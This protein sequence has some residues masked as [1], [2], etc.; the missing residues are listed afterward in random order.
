MILITGSLG[1]V[2]SHISTFFEKKNIN[3]VGID[4]LSYSYKNNIFNK[5]KHYIFDISDK[6]K[7][8][9][10]FKKYNI[11]T[12]IH[13]AAFSYVLEAESNKN[14]YFNN[15]VKKTKNFINLCKKYGIK[16][17][18]FMSSS[19][20]YGEN[21]T[22]STFLENDPTSPKNFYGKNKLLIENYLKKIKFEKLIILRLFNV[23]GVFNKKFKPFKFKNK[24]YQRLIFKLFH[25]LKFKKKTNINFIQIKNKKIFPARDFIDILDLSKILLKILKNLS[26]QKKIYEIFNIGSGQSTSIDEI[27]KLINKKFTKKLLINYVN[28]SKKELVITKA[29]IKKIKKFV[30]YNKFVS[31][32]KSLKSYHTL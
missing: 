14:K 16:N 5:K 26:Q 7:L 30:N 18:I 17:F 11:N 29:S 28:L 19:N 23:I 24:N 8:I 13:C 9:N 31:L 4:N 27:T 15:N 6:I 10:I 21:L 22:N 20:V 32:E 25:N 3:F 1:Y 2:G 12:V